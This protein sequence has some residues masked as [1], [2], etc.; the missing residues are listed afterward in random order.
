MQEFQECNEF[1]EVSHL[2]FYATFFLSCSLVL[3][4][5][6]MKNHLQNN[7]TYMVQNFQSLKIK[8]CN[9]N[10]IRI[11]QYLLILQYQ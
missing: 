2:P 5:Q 6:V 10:G 3:I 9:M 11:W 1:N 4:F 8:L 7:D